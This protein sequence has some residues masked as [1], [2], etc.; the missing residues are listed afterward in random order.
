ML[1]RRMHGR[2]LLALT[3]ESVENFANTDRIEIWQGGL[4]SY[5]ALS[6]S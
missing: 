2:D 5:R 3:R 1:E 4:R 6:V